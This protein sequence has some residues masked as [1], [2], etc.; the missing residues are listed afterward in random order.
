MNAVFVF[1]S[2]AFKPACALTSL[3]A[4][5]AASCVDR[6]VAGLTKGVEGHAAFLGAYPEGNCR[7][8]LVGA[9]VTESRSA[10]RQRKKN[11]IARTQR[12]EGKKETGR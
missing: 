5:Y 4:L 8:E 3:A 6:P 12:R 10:A 1:C 9:A 2:H 11:M 7:R